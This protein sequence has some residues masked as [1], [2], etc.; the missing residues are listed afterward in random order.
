VIEPISS[1]SGD[2]DL[3]RLIAFSP[4]HDNLI[5]FGSD[6]GKLCIW[7]PQTGNTVAEHANSGRIMSVMFLPNGRPTVLV[8][9]LEGH[10]RT[11][12][13]V[14]FS[15]DGASVVSGSY[16]RTLR[17]L[18]AHSGKLVS[19]PLEGHTSA[20]YAVAY[21]LARW[22]SDCFRLKR[23]FYP[24]LG[25]SKRGTRCRHTGRT[26]RSGLLHRLVA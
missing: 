25:R 5:V 15:P 8:G 16:D 4:G 22:G 1:E 7:D 11:V 26:H 10:T 9:P 19:G 14:V 21:S 20:I 2:T 12:S 3:V 24:P 6:D 17:I 18:D 13:S 23:P